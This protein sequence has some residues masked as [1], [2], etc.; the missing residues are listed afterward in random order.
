MTLQ[1][2]TL[3]AWAQSGAGGGGSFESIATAVGTGSSGTITFSSIPST[4]QH[5]HLRWISRSDRAVVQDT[6]QI[7][8]NSSATGYAYHLINGDGAGASAQASSAT[9]Y[10]GLS[11]GSCIGSSTAANIIAAGFI[12]IYDYASSTK[13]KT[14]RTFFGNDR[15]GA[16]Q[17]NLGSGLWTSTNAITS[18]TI[19]PGGAGNFTTQTQI[20]LYGIKGA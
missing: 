14:L 8:F 20:A 9:T 2:F 10:I 13:A 18:I 3:P 16:G 12:D 5:L 15:N 6:M 19:L 11:P 4:Y 1:S 7:T 17:S